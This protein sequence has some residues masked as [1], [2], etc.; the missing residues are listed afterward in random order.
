MAATILHRVQRG[1][2]LLDKKMPG[3][4][5]KIHWQL[6]MWSNSSCVLGQTFGNYFQGLQALGLPLDQAVELGFTQKEDGGTWS[7]RA[8]SWSKLGQYWEREIKKRRQKKCK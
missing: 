6:W 5:D 4:E 7:Q 8:A 3:W 1:A 2:K